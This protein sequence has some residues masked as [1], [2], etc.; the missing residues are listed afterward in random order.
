M[1]FV[2]DSAIL[3][4]HLLSPAEIKLYALYCKKRNK[5]S[6]GWICPDARTAAELKLVRSAVYKAR[7]RLEK[8]GWVK[9]FDNGFIVPLF[10]FDDVSTGN[11]DVSTGN[12]DVSTGNHDVSTGNHDV[13]TGNHDVSTGNHDVSTG[14]HDVSTGNHALKESYQPSYQ[15]IKPTHF[16][17][18]SANSAEPESATA[19]AGKK[20]D[21]KLPG[22]TGRKD[23]SL[24]AASA[25]SKDVRVSH[26]A[27]VMV[28][29]I[30]SRYP[31]KDLWDRVI[32]EIGD[33]PNAEFFRSSWEIWRSFDGKPTNYEKWLFEPAKTGFPPEVFEKKSGGPAVDWVNVGKSEPAEKAPDA[34]AALNDTQRGEA[35]EIL[36]EMRELGEDIAD[37]QKWYAPEIW[38][39]LMEEIKKG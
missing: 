28:K 23:L 15:P 3:N 27:I 13:S 20:I 8:K 16:T 17:S 35:L 10:G 32:R 1:A 6:G 21:K 5:E 31:H 34:A 18:V 12:H 25:K 30:S 19:T 9:H 22:K 4:F 24:A 38:S 39:W 26:P 33:N 11:H 7:I 36:I 29:E 37:F 14:N 2:P